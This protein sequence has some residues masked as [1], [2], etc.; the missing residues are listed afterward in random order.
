VLSEERKREIRARAEERAG[1]EDLAG[2][3]ANDRLIYELRVHQI[4]LEM[5]NDELLRS[6]SDL[7]AARERYQLL[8]D[9]A[10]V[11]YLVL[12][13]EGV[14]REMNDAAARLFGSSGKVLV[15]KPMVV[16][17]D[18]AF[19][20]PLFEHLR[21][22]FRG[23][24]SNPQNPRLEIEIAARDGNRR[25]GRAESRFEANRAGEHQCLMAITDITERRLMEDD[26]RV[27]KEEAVAA[28]A[29]KSTFLANMSHEI[30]TPMNGVLA[31]TELVLDTEL[32]AEQREYLQKVYSSA[33]SLL[34]IIDDILDLSKI[35][36][37]KLAIDTETFD[38][39]ELLGAIRDLFQQLA[40][41]KSVELHIE[42][43]D[44]LPRLIEGDRN[45]TRQI[46]VNLVSNAVKFTEE[47]S[48][49]IRARPDNTRA[50]VIFEVV[51]TGPG[52]DEADRERIFESFTQAD[53]SLSRR[54]GGAG[55]GLSISRQLARR[56]GGNLTF[57]ST[58]G[59]GSLFRLTFPLVEGNP[60]DGG[61]EALPQQRT[62][63]QEEENTANLSAAPRHILVAE[64]NAIN[65]LVLR[66]IL[67][68][69]GYL[70]ETVRSGTA[71]IEHLVE[72]DFDAVL[73]DISMP[74]MDGI[75]ATREVRGGRAA[76][77]NPSIP[78]VAITA[79]A[80]AGDQE[81]FIEAG[82]NGYIAK[83]FTQ[84]TVLARIHEIFGA[85][86]Q[87]G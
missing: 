81:R 16:F 62:T 87:T 75:A 3:Q 41:A 39:D 68:K 38:T 76:V 43:S 83:P 74:G 59:A 40:D 53:G 63:G 45:R 21:A 30:R 50:E 31:L 44:T 58:P 77:K 85:A 49:S 33:R 20:T 26:L 36:A 79:H 25:W 70:V 1:N 65:A 46:L 12:S 2:Q 19:H 60:G 55:L 37:N 73:M 72:R 84:D 6:E 64:D 54:Y 28:N 34:A 86:D 9:R 8:F 61:G 23:S 24:E 27:A 14:I 18:P 13:P 52:I 32:D 51:D 17:I 42:R 4:E 48:I 66:K 7:E 56:L 29:A 35:E 71:V 15:G 67:E 47:G 82:M 78:I 80:M 10:P 5:Q 22:V 57:E 11:A 69:S